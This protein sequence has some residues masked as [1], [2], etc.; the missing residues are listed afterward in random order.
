MV[1]PAARREAVAHLEERYEMNA[2]RAC[3]SA[4]TTSRSG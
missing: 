1:T 2:R 3:S 4:T